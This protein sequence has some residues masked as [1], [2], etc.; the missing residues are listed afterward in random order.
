[1]E[2]FTSRSEPRNRPGLRFDQ[3]RVWHVPLSIIENFGSEPFFFQTPNPHGRCLRAMAYGIH[4]AS[5]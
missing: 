2:F 1:M 3:N 4:I 5:M